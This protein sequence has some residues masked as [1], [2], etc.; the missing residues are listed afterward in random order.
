VGIEEP[1]RTSRRPAPVALVVQADPQIRR[2]LRIALPH[3]GFRVCE[4]AT[5]TEALRTAEMRRPDILILGLGLPDVDGLE[6][7]RRL[8]EWSQV[9]IVVLS[10]RIEEGDKIA[11]L[12]AGADDHISKPF[13]MGEL[14]ARMRAALRRAAR[15]GRGAQ[16]PDGFSVT[17]K[18]QI[19]LRH[20]RVMITGNEIH[21]TPVE[22][23]LLMILS[24]NAGRTVPQRQLLTEAWGPARARQPHHLH[25]YMARLRGKLESDPTHPKYV[26]TEQGVGYR[27]AVESRD[28]LETQRPVL[29]GLGR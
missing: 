6:V 3:H 24:R 8:R 26:L 19:D 2:F 11:A 22:H 5:A 18:I 27:L 23:R 1:T 28:R 7:I 17:G 15:R 16:D 14:L 20:R 25:V 4:A 29:T 9:P 10:A 12:D 21:L 13:G